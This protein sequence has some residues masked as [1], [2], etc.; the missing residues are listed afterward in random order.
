MDVD[1]ALIGVMRALL[2]NRPETVIIEESMNNSALGCDDGF[3]TVHT[4][5][6][7]C[8][9]TMFPGGGWG[10]MHVRTYMEG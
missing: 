6:M 1:M 3:I 7:L 4:Y 2:I 9:K 8:S 10:H 5:N